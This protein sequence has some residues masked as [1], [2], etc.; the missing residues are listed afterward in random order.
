VK[1]EFL[2]ALCAL[3]PV[4]QARFTV[5]INSEQTVANEVQARAIT[6]VQKLVAKAK[7]PP[8]AKPAQ[9]VAG[10]PARSPAVL[11]N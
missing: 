4:L 3:A 10:L 11:R 2:Y 7:K 1:A 9:V 6:R 8:R 5:A